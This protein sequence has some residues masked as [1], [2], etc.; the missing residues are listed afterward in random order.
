MRTL[1]LFILIT[2]SGIFIGLCT[3]AFAGNAIVIPGVDV[4]TANVIST[5]SIVI[6]PVNTDAISIINNF[7]LRVLGFL[8][9]FISGVA[10][11]YLVIIGAYMV[12]YSENEEKIKS[13]RKQIVYAIIGFLFLNIPGTI[14]TA[15]FVQQS[16]KA[17]DTATSWSEI[18][19]YMPFWELSA[20]S[21]GG[22]FTNFIAFLKVF[23]FGVAVLM[24]T[25]GLF[26][27]IISAGDE[28]SR[29][30]GRNRL[31]YG[32]LGLIFLGFVEG[33]SSL[34]AGGDFSAGGEI[35]TT[36]SKLI[37]IAIYFSGPIAIFFLIWGSYYYIT[38]GGD[39]ERVK[40][41]KTIIINTFIA[42]LILLASFSF[43]KDLIKFTLD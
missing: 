22:V 34:I 26:R 35:I 41:G 23:I 11:I 14:Y 42:T 3:P 37:G 25:W 8:K 5:G 20:F 15:F 13:Q 4:D 39:E 32:T 18:I 17:I 33:W 29:K 24:F 36:G 16:G 28:E 2:I 43:M 7:G 6:A 21:S 40:K 38:S 9:S 12:V 30:Q 19:T 1:L 10:L 27:M 31:L